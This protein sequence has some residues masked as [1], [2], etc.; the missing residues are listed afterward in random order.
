[1]L[2]GSYW[3]KKTTLIVFFM[4]KKNEFRPLE[5]I[6]A[7][8]TTELVHIFHKKYNKASFL[9]AQYGSKKLQSVDH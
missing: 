6:L 3:A 2:F 5:I 8:K 4:K 1:M 7:K 9:L